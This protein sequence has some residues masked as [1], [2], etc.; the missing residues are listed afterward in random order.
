MEQL[1]KLEDTLRQEQEER[2]LIMKEVRDLEDRCKRNSFKTNHFLVVSS[3][4]TFSGL[5][6]GPESAGIVL[7]SGGLGSHLYRY[8]YLLV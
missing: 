2:A 4:S 7:A 5:V 3:K 6:Q 1:L 8:P